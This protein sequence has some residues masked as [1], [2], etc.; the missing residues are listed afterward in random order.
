[1]AAI[2]GFSP[3]GTFEQ[4]DMDNWEGCSQSG[5]GAVSRRHPLNIQMGMG[6]TGFDEN[7]NAWASEARLSES[8][9][10]EYYRH[11]AQLM[12]GAPVWPK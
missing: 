12:S 10:R 2:R 9:H 6:H 5:K 7:L 4:D 11:W 8:N 3:S 1:L